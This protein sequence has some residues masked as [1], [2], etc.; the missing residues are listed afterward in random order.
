MSQKLMIEEQNMYHMQCEHY[1]LF[2]VISKCFINTLH[3]SLL[4][5]RI[6]MV[7]AEMYRNSH[8]ELEVFEFD[9]SKTKCI[10][11]LPKSAPSESNLQRSFKTMA[12]YSP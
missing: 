2:T 3:A 6:H 4:A 7:T 1:A 8:P 10:L 12:S 9:M 5:S 11:Q